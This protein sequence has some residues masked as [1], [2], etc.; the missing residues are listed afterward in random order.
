MACPIEGA[1]IGWK[2][3]VTDDDEY[4]VKILVPEDAKRSSATTDKCRCSKAKVLDIVNISTDEH[5]KS[6][7]NK[8]YRYTEY[9]VG[10]IVKPDFFDENRWEECSH[11]IH[12]FVDKESALEYDEWV[13]A[14]R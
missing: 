10:E 3:I 7:T 11:G 5:I 9:I 13:L 8:T 4:L 14:K 2:K 1:F 6:I 12:F